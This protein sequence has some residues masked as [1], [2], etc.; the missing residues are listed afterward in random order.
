MFSPIFLDTPKFVLLPGLF[1]YV[2]YIHSQLWECMGIQYL[3]SYKQLF[4]SG[5]I[6]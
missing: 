1:Q 2:Y 6:L 4:G 5:Q 3:Q